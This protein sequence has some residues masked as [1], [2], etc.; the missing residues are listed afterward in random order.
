LTQPIFILPVNFPIGIIIIANLKLN[1]SFALT[2]DFTPL[3][4]SCHQKF[5]ASSHE[6]HLQAICYTLSALHMIS[7]ISSFRLFRADFIIFVGQ[8]LELNP[9]ILAIAQH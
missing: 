8:L 2:F 7:L 6:S 3:I 9:T 4:L 1:L 5:I